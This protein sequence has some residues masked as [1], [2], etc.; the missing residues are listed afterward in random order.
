MKNNQTESNNNVAKDSFPGL[1]RFHDLLPPPHPVARRSFLRSLGLGA[2]LLTP[3]AGIIAGAGRARAAAFGSSGATT[4]DIDI[5]RFLAAAEL[6]EEDLWLQYTELA[7]G[8]DTYKEAIEAIDDDFPQYINDNWDD[9]LSHATFLNAY[10]AS[11][12]GEPVNLDAFRTLPSSKATGAQQI[13][14]LTNL[15]NLTVDTSW[16]IRYR[17]TENPDF[18]ATFP[19]LINIVNKP[20]I[21]PHDLPAGDRIQAIAN[22]A[23]FHFG[24]IEQG[25]SSLYDTMSLKV[26]DLTVLRIVTSIGGT[27]V[28]HFAIWN[29]NAGNVVPVHVQGLTFP[30]IEEVFEGDELRQKDLI[31]PEPCQFIDPS[32]PP[33]SII[34][35]TSLENAGAM[36]AVTALTSS[37]L[38]I[39][40]SQ[41]FFD[42]LNALAAAADAPV[43]QCS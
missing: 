32:L 26:T 2:A 34:R 10:I 6:L 18:G 33:C 35:P 31:M 39:G 43:R 37:G 3:A 36:A 17:S 1:E 8:N 20:A 21:P 19:Q 30:D 15:G 24:T 28:F 12:G 14:R 9:E 5:M 16:W 41:E 38:F 29:D 7:N 25:G 40:Q 27:E 42:T 22:T 11:V 4:G 23:A 13:G